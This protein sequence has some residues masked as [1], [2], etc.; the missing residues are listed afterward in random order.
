MPAAHAVE[1]VDSFSSIAPHAIAAGLLAIAMLVWGGV[2]LA[3][4]GLPAP[5]VLLL[6]LLIDDT[7]C[8][9]SGVW[10]QK[11]PSRRRGRRA[12]AVRQH[13]QLRSRR[14]GDMPTVMPAV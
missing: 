3:R 6:G 9:E 1:R 8:L 12:V 7:S 14:V 10:A 2:A 4:A 13:G 5:A 11:S